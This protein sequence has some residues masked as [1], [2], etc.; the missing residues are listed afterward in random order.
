MT[1]DQPDDDLEQRSQQWEAE[2]FGCGGLL[3]GFARS[4]RTRESLHAEDVY[5]RDGPFYCAS[6][7]SDVVCVEKRDHFAHIA[8]LTPASGAFESELHRDCKQEICAALQA[9]HPHGKWE[10]ERPIRESKAQKIAA[11]KPDISGRIGG[12]PIAIEVQASALSISG[13]IK[14]TRT[15]SQR[16]ISMLWIV[17]LRTELDAEPF[18][19]RLFERY[20][21][22]IYFGRTFYWWRGLGA[23]VQP[24]HYGPAT[25]HI[26]PS[27]WYEDGQLMTAGDYEA[28]YKVI[29]TPSFGPPLDIS[30]SFFSEDRGEFTPDNE[31]KAVP[32]CTIW[33]DS[34]QPWW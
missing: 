13:I 1:M 9:L 19:P 12:V 24:V 25:R 22:S 31:R 5:K 30:R 7:H 4:L 34:T 28:Q 20:F 21:H 32:S 17:P 26:P 27:E 11:V 23:Q 3:G 33:R 10:V 2:E 15:Y 29:K 6:C 16:G 8:P 18:R 14:R